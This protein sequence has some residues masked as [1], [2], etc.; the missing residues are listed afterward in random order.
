MAFNVFL[1]LGQLFMNRAMN[2]GFRL[3]GSALAIAVLT[4]RNSLSG[5][6]NRLFLLRGSKEEFSAPLLQ[7]PS[8]YPR[9]GGGVRGT[10]DSATPNS[11]IYVCVSCMW[12]PKQVLSERIGKF[13]L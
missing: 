9:R 6:R 4:L 12:Y 13:R 5:V 10:R 11:F 2:R 3:Q 1:S 8:V 7:A